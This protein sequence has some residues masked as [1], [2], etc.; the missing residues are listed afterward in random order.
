MG[1]GSWRRSWTLT[2]IPSWPPRHLLPAAHVRT[3]SSLFQFLLRSRG[4][5]SVRVFLPP[6]PGPWGL[7][8]G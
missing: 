4:R 8:T 1:G 7:H 5:P 6:Y 3:K 2:P